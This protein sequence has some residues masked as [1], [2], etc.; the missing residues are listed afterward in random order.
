MSKCSDHVLGEKG[1]T[2]V[3][4]FSKY[5]YNKVDIRRLIITGMVEMSHLHHRIIDLQKA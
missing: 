2:H 4:V 3:T 5:E 1:S